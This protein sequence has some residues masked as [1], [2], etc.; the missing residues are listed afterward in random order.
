M[1]VDE[2]EARE[3][4]TPAAELADY[5]P[6]PGSVTVFSAAWCGYCTALKAGLARAGTEVREVMIEEDPAAERIAIA[7][8]GGDWLIPT[9]VFSDG[10]IRVNPGVRGVSERLQQIDDGV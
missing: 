3:P 10:S 4:G 9:V 1:H 8:N 5:L 2:G 6:R 7:A